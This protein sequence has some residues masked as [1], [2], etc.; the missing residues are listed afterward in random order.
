MSGGVLLRMTEGKLPLGSC[1]WAAVSLHWFGR[2]VGRGG[3]VGQV[4][5]G[6]FSND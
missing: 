3:P 4:K 1:R 5:L 6:I 2:A